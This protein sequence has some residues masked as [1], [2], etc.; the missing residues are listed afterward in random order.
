MTTS[1]VQRTGSYPRL[2]DPHE[3]VPAVP[4]VHVGFAGPLE[5]AVSD[6][7]TDGRFYLVVN[8]DTLAFA[9]EQGAYAAF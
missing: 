6:H 8:R 7:P 3:L 4:V 5:D 2:P 9:R 1:V